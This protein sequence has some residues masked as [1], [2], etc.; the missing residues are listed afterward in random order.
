MLS[1]QHL[2]APLVVESAALFLAERLPELRDGEDRGER[3]K[4]DGSVLREARV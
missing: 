4:T 1:Q 3:E 2:V